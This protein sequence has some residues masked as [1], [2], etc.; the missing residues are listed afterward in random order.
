MYDFLLDTNLLV[1]ANSST[2]RFQTK[3]KTILGDVIEEK[4]AGCVS[5]QN[6]YEFY[7]VITDPKR[8]EVAIKQKQAER[9]LANFIEAENLPKIFPKETNL[10][11]LL[12][13]IRKYKITRQEIFDAQLVATMMDNEV[14]TIYTADE[15]FFRKFD[16]LEVVNPFS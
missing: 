13:L 5:I 8:V 15:K 4:L 2:S 9:L 14:Q 3:A 12:T 16:F 7:A 6:I 11:N 10:F 1:Y